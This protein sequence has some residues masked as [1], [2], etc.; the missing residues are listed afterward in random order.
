[1]EHQMNDESKKG[2]DWSLPFE[3]M[4]DASDTVVGAILGQRKDK[5]FQTIYYASRTFNEPQ[6]NYAT[7]E[8]EFLTIIVFAFN[9][10]RSYLRGFKVIVYTDHSILIYCVS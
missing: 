6:L 10:F 3:V 2:P 8:K 1:M 4:C 7:T 9:K 5:V